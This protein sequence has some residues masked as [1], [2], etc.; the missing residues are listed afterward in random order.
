METEEKVSRPFLNE[1]LILI[2]LDLLKK[3]IAYKVAVS[4]T[5]AGYVL[6]PI[7]RVGLI[8]GQS[9]S[10]KDHRKLWKPG[11]Q[12]YEECAFCQNIP[13]FVQLYFKGITELRGIQRHSGSAFLKKG[14]CRPIFAIEDVF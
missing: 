14:C 12:I 7:G 6:N 13:I 5:E 10:S 9:C 2:E 4:I 8:G 3:E 1:R 11:R